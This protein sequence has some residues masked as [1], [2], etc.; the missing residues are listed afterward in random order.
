MVL[1]RTAKSCGPDTLTPV[2]SWRRQTAGD[3]GKR[4]RLTGEST[5][6]TVK[7]SRAGM[8]GSSGG[9]VVTN[10]CVFT[11]CTRGCGCIGRPAFPT[12]FVGRKRHSNLGR[13]TPREYGSVS[14]EC[15]YSQR[16]V[17]ANAG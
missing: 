2:S 16:V 6:Q 11:F 17:P 13:F 3:G 7:P 9:P 8:P 5:K 15:E 10:S 14:D 1:L 4:A 12:P